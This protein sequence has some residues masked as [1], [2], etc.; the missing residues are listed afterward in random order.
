MRW[1]SLVAP[2][3]RAG[4]ETIRAHLDDYGYQV[5]R[6]AVFLRLAKHPSK[7]SKN[8]DRE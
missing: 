1:Y 7:Y 3:E 8:E 5:R 2:L 4:V 6:I